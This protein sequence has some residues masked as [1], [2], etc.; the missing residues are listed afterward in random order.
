M[1][2]ITITIDGDNVTVNQSATPTKVE[3]ENKKFFIIMR[4]E[5]YDRDCWIEFVT[6]DYIKAANKIRC[7]NCDNNNDYIYNLY[8]QNEDSTIIHSNG[9]D[10]DIDK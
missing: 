9:T 5:K 6:D 10:W 1:A 8:I 3:Q 2:K 4:E 7:L